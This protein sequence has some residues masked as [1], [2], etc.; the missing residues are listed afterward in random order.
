[1][2]NENRNYKNNNVIDK[3]G[4]VLKF[5]ELKPKWHVMPFDALEEVVKVFEYGTKKYKEPFTY[6]SGEIPFS[7]LFSAT[8]RHLI[9][10]YFYKEDIDSDSKVHHLA[11]AA[12]NCLMLLSYYKNPKI[13]DRP[14][15]ANKN[16]MQK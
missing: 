9:T 5:D 13:D 6:A 2:D 4:N 12:A 11:C 10:W 8:M 15:Y 1:M 3:E 16:K 14:I 7:H